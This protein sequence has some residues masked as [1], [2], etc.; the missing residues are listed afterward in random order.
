MV[1]NSFESAI[2]VDIIRKE[3]NVHFLNSQTNKIDLK[4]FTKHLYKKDE[5]TDFK[6][7]NFD[8]KN[9]SCSDNQLLLCNYFSSD[10]YNESLSAEKEKPSKRQKLVEK[11]GLA[12]C[13]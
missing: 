12:H 9:S 1:H 7:N 2:G 5:H 6:L 4:M 10:A 8:F 3:T 11:Q 13:P